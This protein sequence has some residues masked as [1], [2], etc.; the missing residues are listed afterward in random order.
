MDN[1]TLWGNDEVKDAKEAAKK[2]WNRQEERERGG[3]ERWR[4]R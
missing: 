1:D 2:K 4:A 3:A